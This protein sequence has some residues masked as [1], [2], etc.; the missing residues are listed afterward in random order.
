VEDLAALNPSAIVVLV[1]IIRQGGCGMPT[2]AIGRDVELETI[3]SFITSIAGGAAALVLEGDP[4]VGKTTLWRAALGLARE[5]ALRVLEASAAE[6]EGML[7]FA[8]LGDLI[9]GVLDEVSAALP[10]PQRR[11]LEVALLRREAEGSPHDMR[12]VG[13]AFVNVLR[14]LAVE[15]ILVA[16]ED[17]QW[18]DRPSARVLAFAARRLREEPVGLLVTRR[19]P[20]TDAGHPELERGL[21]DDRRDHLALGGLS[22]GALHRVLSERIGVAFPRPM[23][24]RLHEVSGGNPFLA[25]EM[26]RALQQRGSRPAP[27]EPL[28]VPRKLRDLV[29]ERSGELP[30][31]ARE[32]ALV[33]SALSQPA[34]DVIEAAFPDSD[35]ARSGLARALEAGLVEFEG[36]RI[37]FT[38]P[39]LASVVY[40]E[41]TPAARRQIHARLVDVVGDPEERAWHLALATAHP[42]AGVAAILDEA[43]ERARTRGAPEAAADLLEHARLLSPPE[44]REE[45]A[46]RAVKS[47]DLWFRAGDAVRTLSIIEDIIKT[48]GPGPSRTRAL[49]LLPTLGGLHEPV[50]GGT[51]ALLE[52]ALAQSGDDLAQRAEIELGLAWQEHMTG[53][54]PEAIAHAGEALRM[55]EKSTSPG[56]VTWA[57]GLVG[58]LR[59]LHGEG[60]DTALMERA[61]AMEES[62]EP[63]SV[64]LRPRWL[65][66][67]MLG[68]A[69]EHA[70]ARSLLD[71]LQHMAREQG[72][73]QWLSPSLTQKAR[74][75][76]L[77][78]A[79]G[80][81][82]RDAEEA[83]RLAAQ[84]AWSFERAFTLS[85]RALVAAH[86]GDEH[87]TRT[88][89]DEALS[90]LGRAGR[91]TAEL[92][93]RATLGLL[94]LSLGD[95]AAADG[96]LGPLVKDVEAA[97]IAEPGVFRCHAN[98][99]EAL[100]GLGH[101]DR[102]IELLERFE[103][104]GTS[105]GRVWAMATAARCRGLLL[106]A[107]GNPADALQA[108]DR[109]LEY[110]DRQPEPFERGRTL[111]SL[112]ALRRRQRQKRSARESL[113]TSLAIFE[114]LGASL[115][116][117]RTRTELARIGGRAPSGGTLTPSEH[118][119]AGLVASGRSNKEV[120]AALFISPRTV[121][122]HLKKV[123]AKLG[124]HSRMELARRIDELRA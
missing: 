85:T 67:I 81:A 87:A 28:P 114:E 33:V 50:R 105:L 89:A 112:G 84:G 29:R 53:S 1:T 120:A 47:A 59:A 2:E 83:D 70:A 23:L 80:E 48:A 40:S 98:A 27:G 35:R 92:E 72:E 103:R 106:A 69:G 55:G 79:W 82:C 115:W 110:H 66:A 97:G 15:P 108:L 43:A 21:P 17:V 57:V 117:E 6:A 38:H 31:E 119:V 78:G 91:S 12:A 26:A 18:L 14:T 65:L 51:R 13:V 63:L 10:R 122:G 109:A 99:I 100:I 62:V 8:S 9:D 64:V 75:G 22:L 30:I 25:L 20:D 124:V 49:F 3:R 101:L 90:V 73:I 113:E 45:A 60:I 58:F 121:E 88:L 56:L 61:A 74:V 94:E 39:L 77:A 5:R 54:V 7:S 95:P 37:R 46:G 44:S 34:A 118:R 123:Y 42:D 11:A 102:A 4:G 71:R 24:R 111:L 107:Q 41:A 116:A 76:L 96:Y 86:R 93:V 36:E 16:V 19:S 68:W 52:K 104:R 32:V